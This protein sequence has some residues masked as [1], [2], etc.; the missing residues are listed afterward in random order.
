MDD[1]ATPP[2]PPPHHPPV[3]E[4]E[5]PEANGRPAGRWGYGLWSLVVALAAAGVFCGGVSEMGAMVLLL[6][7]MALAGAQIFTHVAWRGPDASDRNR[8]VLGPLLFGVFCFVV[9]VAPLFV[10]PMLGAAGP[11][12]HAVKCASN[13][14]QIGRGILVYAGANGGAFPQRFEPL[15]EHCDVT[16]AVFICP[17]SNDNAASGATMQAIKADFVKPGRCS[18]VY[19]GAGLTVA[20]AD[21]NTVVAY[22]NA[23]PCAHAKLGTN[24]LFGDGHMDALNAN[25]MKAIVGA[26][27]RPVRF[28]V[29]Q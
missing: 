8:P 19:L 29:G 25:Q 15:I 3:L 23:S 13:L 22:E 14:R 7:A 27:T 5:R 10:L 18:Y 16:P 4:Y 28:T 17:G 24:V 1:P 26:T 20:T 2:T 11:R 21:A 9:I 12:A 6:V